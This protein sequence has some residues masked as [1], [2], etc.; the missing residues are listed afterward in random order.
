MEVLNAIDL[1]CSCGGWALAARGLPIRFVT[2]VD[3]ADDALETWRLNHGAQHPD[4]A[5]L[6]A[7]ISSAAGRERI[8]HAI[9][10]RPI[11]L[12]LGGITCEE[13]SPARNKDKPTQQTM[14]AWYELIDGF[15]EMVT[16]TAP[17]WWC[18]EDVIQVEKHLPGPLVFGKP[19]PIRR[20]DASKF[21]PQKRKRT[22]IGKFPKRLIPEPGPRTLAECLRPGPY[23]SFVGANE[24]E[25]D[26]QRFYR[27]NTIR[28]WDPAEP[29][30][31]ITSLHSRHSKGAMIETGLAPRHLE[32]QEAALVQGFPADFIFL[33]AIGR[34][35][36]MIAQAIPI[37]VGR[38]ILQAVC[39]AAEK[40]MAAEV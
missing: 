37:Y 4:C 33:G 5:V 22:F 24:C 31:T 9:G 28:V 13:V 32:W 16:R 25:R 1:G 18:I 23:R 10:G 40:R 21:G 14:D 39:K 38:A 27:P 11:D 6:N 30:Y 8:L 34:A 17:P 12:L 3:I 36:K 29:G 7:D 15:F 26:R 35:S 20:I 19:I 2:V